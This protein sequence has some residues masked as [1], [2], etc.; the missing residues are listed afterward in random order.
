M[1]NATVYNFRDAAIITYYVDT[2]RNSLMAAY[3]DIDRDKDE[4]ADQAASFDDYGRLSQIVAENIE[5]LQV[6][7]FFSG[8]TD[9]RDLTRAWTGPPEMNSGKL[10]DERVMAVSIG[11]TSR[12]PY[13]EGPII[14]SRPALFNRVAGTAKDNLTRSTL[15]E[16]IA[17][18]NVN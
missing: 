15:I 8:D 10:D 9:N 13:G 4:T 12:S 5:D 17:L 18:R 7:Y 2:A 1:D 6:F 14:R 11:L 3:H 16:T